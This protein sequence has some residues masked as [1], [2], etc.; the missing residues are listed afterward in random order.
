VI[1]ENALDMPRPA[2]VRTARAGLVGNVVRLTLGN[3]GSRV[4]GLAREQVVA[5]L[6]GTTVAASTFS[7]ASR[8]PT[9][10]YDLLIGGAL[11][12]ALVPVFAEVVA[13]QEAAIARGDTPSPDDDLGAVAGAVLGVALI[14]LMP[15]VVFLIA[16][17]EPLIAVLGAGFAPEDQANATAL[18]RL[19]MPVVVLTGIAAVF[20][21]I[22]LARREMT[23]PAIAP[24]TYN[25]GII[26]GAV[27]LAPWLGV[28]SLVV[29]MLVGAAC[30]VWVQRPAT[31]T[32]LRLRIPT[33]GDWFAGWRHPAV[34][35]ILHL[36]GP[37]AG[38][39]VVSAAA[40]ALDTRLASQTGDGSLAAM[41]YA[42][43]VVQLPLGLVA[44]AL[45]AAALPVLAGYGRLG[46]RDVGFQNTLAGALD[47]AVLMVT[48]LMVGAILLREPIVRLLFARGAFDE[49]GV[50]L[51]TTALLWY[52]PQLPFV[53]VDQLLIAAFYA[54]QD[55]RTPVLAGVAGAAIF[56][57]VAIL[58]TPMIGMAGL[59]GAN[60]VQHAAH[61]T[62]LAVILKRR[63]F[64]TGPGRLG[65]F[66][67]A[68]IGASAMCA[69]IVGLEAVLPMPTGTAELMLFVMATG[70]AGAG[71]YLVALA[72]MR[73]P[74]VAWVTGRIVA[75][76]SQR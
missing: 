14:V 71:S 48:P 54:V 61:A 6:F 31:A 38:G 64:A 58:A 17:A 51:T 59:V 11:S 2:P 5:A 37:V 20:Q 32:N 25:L 67:R 50:A 8:V 3:V 1:S 65:A 26:I 47:A 33:L 52:A 13:R 10:V 68:A 40:V 30:Q 74:E 45:S 55:T 4:L 63:G 27:A 16:V 69:V 9:M 66:A 57:C 35:R 24:A 70:G 42:T 12:S 7:A 72:A 53:A 60:T 46:F 76:R 15:V 73:G 28:T 39:L 22:L 41:R 19:A 49:V 21:A 29:G 18:V 43:T 75:M 62:I 36:Y 23:R 56:G 34:R 44:S